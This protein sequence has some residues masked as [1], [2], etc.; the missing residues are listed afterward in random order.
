PTAEYCSL[1]L[2]DALPICFRRAR[3]GGGGVAAPRHLAVDRQRAPARRDGCGRARDPRVAQGVRG[4]RDLHDG[5]GAE[6][7][8]DVG[9]TTA[10]DRKS[11]RLNSSHVKI[12]Y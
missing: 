11:T 7:E 3:P 4:G 5:A 1:A 6:A 9:D 8:V 12:S 10:A 2:H